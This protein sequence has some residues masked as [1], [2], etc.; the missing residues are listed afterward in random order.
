[1]NWGWGIFSQT[2][3]LAVEIMQLRKDLRV[4]TPVF[5]VN[6]QPLKWFFANIFS[7]AIWHHLTPAFIQVVETSSAHVADVLK[8]SWPNLGWSEIA[9]FMPWIRHSIPLGKLENDSWSCNKNDL[10]K[11]LNL[12]RLH[13][14]PN[15]RLPL[16]LDMSILI[17]GVAFSQPCFCSVFVPQH[18]QTNPID[19]VHNEKVTVWK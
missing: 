7:Q 5:L 10:T 3:S 18:V 13:P 1:M 2:K 15:M 19:R 14:N 6:Y 9:C 16:I 8:F 4:S 12:P 11:S 17:H